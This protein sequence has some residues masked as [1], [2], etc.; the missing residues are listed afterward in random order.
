MFSQNN[1]L[2]GYILVDNMYLKEEKIMKHKDMFKDIIGYDDIKKT[3]ERVID[4]LNNQDKYKKL[5]SE[6]PQG[7]LLYGEPGTGKTSFA[8]AIM[9]SVNRKKYTIR[10]NSS[11]GIFI[12]YM[13]NVFEEAKKE[14][15]SIILLDDLDKFPATIYSDEEFTA[16]QSLLDQVKDEDVFIIATVNEKHKLPVSL[17]RSGRFDIKIRIDN[18]D[19]KDSLKIIE[20]L[21]KKKKIDKDVNIKNIA[22]ILNGSSCADINKVC[23]QAAIYAGYL[24]KKSIGM[25]E[26]IRASLEHQYNTNIED[27]N[28]EDKY[29]LETAY[30]EAGHAL[31]ANLLSPGD[32]SFITIARTDSDTKGITIHHQNEY[33]FDDIEFMK[34]RAKVL[35]AG[36]AS[37][38]IVF[39]KCDT[40]TTDD[41][42]RA[43]KIVERFVDNYCMDNFNSWITSDESDISEKYKASKADNTVKLLSNSF[44]NRSFLSCVKPLTAITK[45]S[46]LLP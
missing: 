21:L 41:I 3:L 25:S 19:E 35:L 36:K 34:S 23:N 26:L 6:I 29:S 11:D 2:L 28:K 5:G 24:N 17:R 7:L 20:H 14:K 27:S 42:D 30:H 33:Y 12:S 1:L 46:K 13:R 4:V 18:P 10:K 9:D 31:I 32:I 39:N 44:I 38:E 43:Y 8:N 37:T 40:G 15:S 22:C 16:V 45:S